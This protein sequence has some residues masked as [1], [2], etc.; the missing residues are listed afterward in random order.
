MEIRDK[1]H[2]GLSY[3]V[4]CSM[5]LYLSNSLFIYSN[6]KSNVYPEYVEFKISNLK[7]EFLKDCSN[8]K[9]K[10]LKRDEILLSY[11]CDPNDE[12]WECNQIYAPLIPNYF[13]WGYVGDFVKNGNGKCNSVNPSL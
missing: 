11:G 3:L 8:S 2:K 10:I 5:G 1:L 7:A 6:N 12:L 9:E 13:A 4:I